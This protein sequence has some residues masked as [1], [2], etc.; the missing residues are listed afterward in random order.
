MTVVSDLW[1]T[2]KEGY[3]RQQ[4]L[5]MTFVGPL[6]ENVKA[7]IKMAMDMTMAFKGINEPVTIEAPKGK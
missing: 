6:Q 7:D 5:A 3:L 2:A 1:I 4:T